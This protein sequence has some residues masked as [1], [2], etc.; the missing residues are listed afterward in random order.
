MIRRV[1]IS[2]EVF[3][4]IRCLQ[5]E[6]HDFHTECPRRVQHLATASGGIVQDYGQDEFDRIFVGKALLSE[7]DGKIL[8]G[9]AENNSLFTWHFTDG[10][11]MWQVIITKCLFKKQ[12]FNAYRWY[13][14]ELKAVSLKS[15]DYS[16][17]IRT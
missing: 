5:F 16:G 8:E 13:D 15:I 2:S 3:D 10:E 11:R 17:V 7:A 14:L 12:L 1:A 4:S 6:M 9:M